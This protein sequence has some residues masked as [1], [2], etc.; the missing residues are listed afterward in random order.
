MSDNS[1]DLVA[2]C[3]IPHTDGLGLDEMGVITDER[4][5]I[6]VD[7]NFKTSVDGVYAIGDVIGGAMLAHKAEEEGIVLAEKLAG[8]NGTSELSNHPGCGLYLA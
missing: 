8:K 4:G 2:I 7:A 6:Q 3:R 5:F 1:F